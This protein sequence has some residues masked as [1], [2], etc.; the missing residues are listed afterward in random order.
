MRKR[1]ENLIKAH[2]KNYHKVYRY[3]DIVVTICDLGLIV[4][5]LV[6]FSINDY[7]KFMFSTRK[8]DTN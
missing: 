1:I 6:Y 7:F 4:L 3:I 2:F 5:G 8:I